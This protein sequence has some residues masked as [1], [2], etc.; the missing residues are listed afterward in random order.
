[1]FKNRLMIALVLLFMLFSLNESKADDKKVLETKKVGDTKYTLYSEKTKFSTKYYID[2]ETENGVETW[3]SGEDQKLDSF[4]LCVNFLNNIDKFAMDTIDKYDSSK[5]TKVNLKRPYDVNADW[6]HNI[7]VYG[8]KDA[9]IHITCDSDDRSSGRGVNYALIS[10]PEMV[11]ALVGEKIFG[12]EKE[13]FFQKFGGKLSYDAIKA[14]NFS[15]SMPETDNVIA[16]DFFFE[17]GKLSAL[18][19]KGDDIYKGLPHFEDFKQFVSPSIPEGLFTKGACLE[20]NVNV[21]DKPVN[22]TAKTKL[23]KNK[24]IYISEF[25]KVDKDTWVK[26]TTSEGV[27]GWV[28]GKSI[29]P[30]AH[31]F[32]AFSRVGATFDYISEMP[33][34]LGNPSN[35]KEERFIGTYMLKDQKWDGI[36]YQMAY[37]TG[38]FDDEPSEPEEPEEKDPD[39]EDEEEPEE[40]S[41]PPVL[42]EDIFVK[43]VITKPVV[44]FLG[45][46]VGSN[47]EEL[48]ALSAKLA[49][50]KWHPIDEKAEKKDLEERA[51]QDWEKP[52]VMTFKNDGVYR[53]NDLRGTYTRGLR[54]TMK[55]GKCVSLE[56][57]GEDLAN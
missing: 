27:E 28:N 4:I 16:L 54:I 36:E 13:K 56:F 50:A 34:R 47:V 52:Y 11:N 5:W 39:D 7:E 43:L 42:S 25:K 1:M 51:G 23:S 19:G 24:I 3:N 31:N 18:C 9:V 2:Q 38:T 30:D 21:L 41:A 40:E 26:V 15:F 35:V 48:K 14:A 20:D 8:K 57:L 53:W 33:L 37:D 44:D 10:D 46:K 22:G 55:K 12:M 17:N 32:S 49:N 29:T 6:N 45:F